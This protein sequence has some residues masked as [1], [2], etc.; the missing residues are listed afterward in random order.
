MRLQTRN[1]YVYNKRRLLTGETVTHTA[2][3]AFYTFTIGYQY[4]ANGHLKGQSYPSG[5][6]VDYAPN[7][8]GQPTKVANGAVNY[9]SSIGYYPNGAM[10][11]FTYGNG[12][13]HTMIQNDRQLP[14][15]S[16][17]TPGVFNDAYTY[18]RNGN[19]Q[20]A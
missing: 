13:V 3:P 5:L 1:V 17:D 19:V 20:L 4:S 8:L 7:A 2:N 11:G 18:D 15:W 6:Q 14:A 16:T 12:I 10:A 9:A